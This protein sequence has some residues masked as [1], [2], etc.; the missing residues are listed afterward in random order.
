MLAEAASSLKALSRLGDAPFAALV[1]PPSFDERI[2]NQYSLF[3][4]VSPALALDEWLAERP[5]LARRVVVPPASS[6]RCGTSST[7]PT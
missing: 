2:V 4:L 6:G 1:E 3:S 7:R 5:Q